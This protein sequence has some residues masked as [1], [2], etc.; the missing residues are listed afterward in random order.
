MNKKPMT[1]AQRVE[2]MNEI[3]KLWMDL[4]P[5]DPKEKR[6]AVYEKMKEFPRGFLSMNEAGTEAHIFSNDTQ[7]TA[8]RLPMDRARAFAATLKVQTEIAW[9]AAGKWVAL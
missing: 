3:Q 7:M 4:D 6:L 8:V 1:V 5:N 2:R 9:S